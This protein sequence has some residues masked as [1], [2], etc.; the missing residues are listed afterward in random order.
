MGDFNAYNIL[1]GSRDTRSKGNEIENFL[2]NN[3]LNILNDC[4]PT[5]KT[6]AIE[7]SI[8]LSICSPQLS[9]D[10]HWSASASP[11]DSDHCHILIT[12]EDLATEEEATSCNVKQAGWD[13]YR[14]SVAWN[15]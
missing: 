15:N 14:T 11:A 10:F 3:N 6:H 5:R 7:T 4:S 12:Y 8:D 13:I 9:T 1:W 2:I